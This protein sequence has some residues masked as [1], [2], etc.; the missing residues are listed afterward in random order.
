M[1]DFDRVWPTTTQKCKTCQDDEKCPPCPVDEAG[2][3]TPL[4][5][6]LGS[7]VVLVAP[8]MRKA[9]VVRNHQSSVDLITDRFRSPHLCN[10]RMV[11]S[12]LS[13][14]PPPCSPA[15]F[16]GPLRFRADFFV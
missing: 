16:H 9:S 4:M 11:P 6:A 7:V 3:M 2:R 1:T 5:S 12:S 8:R 14:Y 15:S 13:S 10:F